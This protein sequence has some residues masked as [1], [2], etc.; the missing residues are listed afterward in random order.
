MVLSADPAAE[1]NPEPREGRVHAF[2]DDALGEHDAVGLA[3]ELRAGR[4]G[5]ALVRST[6]PPTGAECGCGRTD[7]DEGGGGAGGAPSVPPSQRGPPS[8]YV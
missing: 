4:V 3:E 8:A 5:R 2:T 7:G 1:S 6:R